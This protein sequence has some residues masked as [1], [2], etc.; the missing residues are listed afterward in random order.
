MVQIKFIRQG[1]NSAIGG[2]SSGDIARVSEAMAKHLVEEAMVA[3]YMD[4][5]VKQEAVKVDLKRT[6]KAKVA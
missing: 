6:R 1:S 3:K 5:P 2:F 4:A